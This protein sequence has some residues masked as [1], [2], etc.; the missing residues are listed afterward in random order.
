MFQV[1]DKNNSV[2]G[3]FKNDGEFISYISLKSN[4]WWFVKRSYNDLSKILSSKSPESITLSEHKALSKKHGL[5]EIRCG[6]N[7]PVKQVV[8]Y[9]DIDLNS[10]LSDFY[11]S[12]CREWG[13][14]IRKVLYM[15]KRPSF[16]KKS[17]LIP[18]SRTQINYDVIEYPLRKG[19][20]GNG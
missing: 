4:Y 11:E 6:L 16:S 10:L 9:P 20:G 1:F 13:W 5:I 14:S 8:L 3:L 15:K 7:K 12:A 2:L 17:C 18:S 19:C